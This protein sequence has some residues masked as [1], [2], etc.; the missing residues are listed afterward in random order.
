MN[1]KYL[2]Y[3]GAPIKFSCLLPCAVSIGCVIQ[4]IV[5]QDKLY[6]LGL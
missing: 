1:A 2:S 3:Y 6:L 5:I 4:D